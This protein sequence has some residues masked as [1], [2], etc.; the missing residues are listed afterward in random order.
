LFAALCIVIAVFGHYRGW[1]HA[2]SQEVGGQST[3]TIT[4]DKDKIEQ[5]K[6][7]AQQKVQDLTH[8]DAAT[9]QPL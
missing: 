1:F 5:D 3:I 4:V 2:E 8:R 9:T 7:A 6:A